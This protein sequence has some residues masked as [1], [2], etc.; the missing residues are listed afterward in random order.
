MLLLIR[1]MIMHT[2]VGL[3]YGYV[4]V[5]DSSSCEGNVCVRIEVRIMIIH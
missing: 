5:V 3:D 4:L 2:I 1:I